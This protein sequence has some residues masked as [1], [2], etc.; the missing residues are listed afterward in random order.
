[1]PGPGGYKVFKAAISDIE[2]G[3]VREFQFNPTYWT[4]E[5]TVNYAV[6]TI[7]GISLPRYQFV[8]GGENIINFELFFNGISHRNGGQGVLSYY[9]W[10]KK[11]MTPQR[12]NNILKVPP[13]KVLFIWPGMY[14]VRSILTACTANWE[15]FFPDGKPKYGR[16]FIQ[17]KECKY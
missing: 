7:P 13:K 2:S 6:I 3:E 9:N 12:S 5:K 14:S 8:S 11:L 1:M 16:L 17:L 15:S 4:E 10:L